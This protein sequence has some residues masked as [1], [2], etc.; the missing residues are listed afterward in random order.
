MFS[1]LKDK[2]AAVAGD[3][4]KLAT[5]GP[6][7]IKE[8]ASSMAAAATDKAKDNAVKLKEQ[9]KEKANETVDKAKDGAKEFAKQIV[10]GALDKVSKKIGGAM[11]SDPDM[12]KPVKAGL[13]DIAGYYMPD[14]FWYHFHQKV[15]QKIDAKTD[16][17]KT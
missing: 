11:G 15:N 5:S 1:G 8:R 7:D 4:Q 10:H 2:A 12:P 17:E 13:Q 16:V 9:V 14:P 6:T 3:A